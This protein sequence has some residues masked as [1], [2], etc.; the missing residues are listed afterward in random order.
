MV[1]PGPGS[2]IKNDADR[3]SRRREYD[4]EPGRT[5]GDVDQAGIRDA[6]ALLRGGRWEFSYYVAGYA[7]ECALKL[8][9]CLCMVHTAW[10]FEEKV[11][12]GRL[13]I[14]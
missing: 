6:N 1:C 10:V 2:I 5:A 12:G 11:E 9:A 8:S 3:T 13:P 4:G 7:V 14:T